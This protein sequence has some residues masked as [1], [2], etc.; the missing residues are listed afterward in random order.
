MTCCDWAKRFGSFMNTD[1]D[2]VSYFRRV[3]AGCDLTGDTVTVR[4]TAD[5]AVSVHYAELVNSEIC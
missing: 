5:E 1:C 2:S 3:P 4:L